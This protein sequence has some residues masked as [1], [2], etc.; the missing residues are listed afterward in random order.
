[1]RAVVLVP[2]TGAGERDLVGVAVGEQVLVDELRAVVRIDPDDGKG[3]TAVT[4]SR[5]SKTHLAALFRTDRFTVQPVEMSVTV[6]VK[7]NSPKLLPPSWPTR[8]ISTN[9]GTASSHSAQVRIGIWDFRRVPGLV[10]DRP[11]GKSFARSPTSFRSMVA[12]LMRISKA[13]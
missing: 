7:Q 9:P 8:S 3:N 5:A 12:A 1:M 13:A 11:R 4:C 10:C 6:R 2:G